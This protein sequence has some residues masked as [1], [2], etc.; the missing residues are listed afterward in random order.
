MKKRGFTL[1]ELIG[2]IALLAVVLGTTVVLLAQLFDYQQKQDEYALG[3]RATNR[4]VAD[5]RNDVR[6][7]GKPEILSE[8]DVLLRWTTETETIEYA[9]EPGEFPGQLN[10]RRAV[11]QEERNRYEIYRL[12]ERTAIRFVDGR[13][14]DAGLVAL[15]LWTV[16]Q[17]T[18]MPNLAELNPFDRTLPESLE[19]RINPKTAANWRTIIVRH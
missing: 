8:G 12:P 19:Q 18:E 17:G 13:N 7:Y 9:S 16:P 4:L 5:F 2:V 10:V 6:A 14:D 3:I 11:R 15:S 1:I